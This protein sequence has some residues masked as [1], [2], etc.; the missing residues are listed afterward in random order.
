MWVGATEG[1]GRHSA[2]VGAIACLGL[3]V[4][5]PAASLLRG[6]RATFLEGLPA[7][8]QMLVPVAGLHLALVYV[9]SRVAGVRRSVTVTVAIV[10][11]E[12]LVSVIALSLGHSRRREDSSP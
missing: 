10:T 11:A 1:R 12:L 7:S 6:R 2:I 8:P 3:F 9:A 5:E 4:V